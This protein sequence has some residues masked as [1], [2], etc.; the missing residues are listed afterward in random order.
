MNKTFSRLAQ[1]VRLP[2]ILSHFKNNIDN[3]LEV[4]ILS[5]TKQDG[6]VKYTY[7][8]ANGLKMQKIL[9]KKVFGYRDWNY[10]KQ[11]GKLEKK[12]VCKND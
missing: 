6:L 5:K 11:N 2:T 10:V 8:I 12:E 7:W 9:R 1:I 3:T 4:C